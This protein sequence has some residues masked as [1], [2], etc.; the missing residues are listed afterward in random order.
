MPIAIGAKPSRKPRKLYRSELGAHFSEGARQLWIVLQRAKETQDGAGAR[1]HVSRGYV[2]RILY[3]DFCP[4]LDL[5][6]RMQKEYGI[7]PGLWLKKPKSVFIPPAARP[8][9]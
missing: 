4:G 6:L 2:C 8:A 1:L 5:C 3:G 9:A 7:N